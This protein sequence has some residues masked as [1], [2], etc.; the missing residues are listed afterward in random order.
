MKMIQSKGLVGLV[1]AV[2]L[3]LPL[4]TTHAAVL[5]VPLTVGNT[6]LGTGTTTNVSGSCGTSG[7]GTVSFSLVRGGVTTNLGTTVNTDASGNF[8]GSVAI[9]SG[10]S[11]GNATL[12]ATCNA[13][14]DVANSSTLNIFVPA[15]GSVTLGA[16]PTLGNAVNVSGTCGSTATGTA[17][18]S[19][20]RN[21]TSTNIGTIN[22]GS[23]GSFNTNITVPATYGA[24]NASLVVTCGGTGT[25][26]NSAAFVLAAPTANITISNS[27]P[28]LGGTVNVSGNCPVSATGNVT[29]SLLRNGVTTNLTTGIT[30]GTVI[31]ANGSF[32]NT[33]TIPE[34]FARGAV[35]LLVNCGSSNPQALSAVLNVGSEVNPV[36][37]NTNPAVGSTVSVTGRCESTLGANGVTTL[38]LNRDG[39]ATNLGTTTLAAD[40][41][42]ATTITIPASASA[43]PAT[44]AATCGPNSNLVSY[45]ILVE[46]GQSTSTSPIVVLPPA[47]AG[48]VAGITL[49][50]VGGATVYPT[51][52]VDTGLGGS[53]D[54]SLPFVAALAILGAASIAMARKLERE[55]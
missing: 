49:A 30:G 42:F 44:L 6:S 5:S 47:Q 12:V 3:L 41:T 2:L 27:T 36:T 50:D 21:G 34:D 33:V 23:Q 51:G 39:V 14:G 8:S 40:G 18:V 19:L 37:F 9:P 28:A 35:T 13:T 31:G 38:T 53:A 4:T 10:Y 45:L 25:T 48:Q 52:G 1:A 43:G 20:V 54:S 11:S 55:A 26:I 46:A 7:S 29:Y 16:T 22:L 15:S 17:Q 24:G 32:N